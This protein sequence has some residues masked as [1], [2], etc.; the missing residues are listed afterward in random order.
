MYI[1]NLIQY[2]WADLN[3]HTSKT[4][5]SYVDCVTTRS[6]SCGTQTSVT[7]GSTK[8][9]RIPVVRD[10]KPTEQY[11]HA[12]YW[13]NRY[14]SL[15]NVIVWTHGQGGTHR[16]QPQRAARL[17]AL[18]SELRASA[19]HRP[20]TVPLEHLVLIY[21]PVPPAQTY[22]GFLNSAFPEAALPSSLASRFRMG[23]VNQC[24]APRKGLYHLHGS[25]VG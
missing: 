8:R 21:P 23:P 7:V 22:S 17:I 4:C 14:P 11:V 3:G 6:W 18:I 20:N 10:N 2:V 9:S 16:P 5:S 15:S 19:E 24:R 1:G 12:A 13:D 25:E